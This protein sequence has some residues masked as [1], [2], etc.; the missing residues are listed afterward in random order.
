MLSK[1]KYMNGLQCPRL[2]WF[3][4]RKALPEISMSD[5]LK[6]SQGHTFEKYAHQLFS[7]GINLDTGNFYDNLKKSS[8]ALD[9]DKNLL[10]LISIP[11][12]FSLKRG[13]GNLYFLN[14]AI[15]LFVPRPQASIKPAL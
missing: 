9:S 12:N 3:A 6:F 7:D 10:N 15:I 13:S 1:S 11:L 8:S 14:S 4:D 5:E 2:L